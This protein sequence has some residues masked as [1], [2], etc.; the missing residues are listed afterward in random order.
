MTHFIGIFGSVMKQIYL[1]IVFVIM[2]AIETIVFFTSGL[3]LCGAWNIISL[4]VSLILIALIQQQMVSNAK[5]RPQQITGSANQS[6]DHLENSHSPPDYNSIVFHKSVAP[7]EYQ[8]VDLIAVPSTTVENKIS[9]Q[10]Y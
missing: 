8:S 3:L 6:Y 4:F 10:K 9:L 5:K 2:V 7:P 1:L